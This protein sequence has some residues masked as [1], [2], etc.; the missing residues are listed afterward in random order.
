MMGIC[1]R[2]Y[3]GTEKAVE[4]FPAKCGDKPEHRRNIGMYHCIDCGAMLMGGM[5]HPGLCKLCVEGKHPSF[6]EVEEL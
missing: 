6:D 2:C 3:D 5:E 1:C 4:I